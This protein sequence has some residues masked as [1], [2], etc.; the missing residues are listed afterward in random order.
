MA[1]VY[2]WDGVPKTV[3]RRH[4]KQYDDKWLSKCVDQSRRE[5]PAEWADDMNLIT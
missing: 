4:G 3:L 5:I 1:K 2:V